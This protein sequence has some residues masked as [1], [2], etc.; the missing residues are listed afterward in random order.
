MSL[1]VVAPPMLLALAVLHLLLIGE[2]KSIEKCLLVYVHM[3][4]IAILLSL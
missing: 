1:K 4:A 3:F 2:I